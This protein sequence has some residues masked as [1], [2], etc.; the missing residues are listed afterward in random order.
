MKTDRKKESGRLMAGFFLIRIAF[1][2][3]R[4][5]LRACCPL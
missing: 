2:R 5:L 4:L 3:F 1:A